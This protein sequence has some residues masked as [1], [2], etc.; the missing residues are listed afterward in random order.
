M[1]SSNTFP[2]GQTLTSSALSQTD[3]NTIMQQITCFIFGIVNMKPFSATLTNGS[4]QIT[5]DSVQGISVGFLITDTPGY[6]LDLYGL[7]GYGTGGSIPAGAKVGSILGN[8]ISMVDAKCEPLNALAS[9]VETIFITD[10]TAG[11]Q[12]RQSWPSNGAPGYSQN[13]NISFIRCIE[14]DDWY[15]KVPDYGVTANDDVSAILNI[16]KT[17][18]WRVFWELRGPTAYERATL[19]KTAMQLEL[20]GDTLSPFN[21]YLVPS[22]GNP[23]RLPELFESK[24]W[25]RSDISMHFNEQVNDEIVTPTV[26]NIPVVV[27]NLNGVQLNLDVE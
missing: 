3:I 26:V 10:P 4:N 23:Q 11:T 24:W 12:V 14:V 7:L 5:V 27:S 6:G 16:E 2:N 25:E 17:R 9:I 8:V 19:L 1:P 21:L 13:D 18:V 22:I 15:N 20:I